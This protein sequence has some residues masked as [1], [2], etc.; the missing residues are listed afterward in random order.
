SKISAFRDMAR[1]AGDHHERLDGKGYPHGIAAEYLD[2]NTRIVT[3]ADIFDALTADRP[4]RKAMP[5][6]TAFEIMEKDLGSA[7]DPEVFAALRHGF[8]RLEGVAEED[9]DKAA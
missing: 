5:V 4:Y 8:A 3:A 6:H 2:L 9:A 7:I 1:I